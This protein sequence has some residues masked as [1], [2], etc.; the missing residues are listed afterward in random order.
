MYPR[1]MIIILTV[2]LSG[3]GQLWA[4]PNSII[5]LWETID[6]RSGEKKAIVNIYKKNQSYYADI[7]KV[8]WKNNENKRC[9]ACKDSVRQNQPIEGLNILWGLKSHSNF[10]WDNG[11]I[12]DPHNGQ[13]YK[14]RV[15]QNNDVLYVRAFLGV[16]LLGRTQEWHRYHS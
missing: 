6:D 12:L 11:N 10:L 7:V 4:K 9:V 16:P 13:I 14:V 1:K 2:F 15:K 3:F 5:G 8:Y